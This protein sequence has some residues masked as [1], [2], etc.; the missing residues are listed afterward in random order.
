MEEVIYNLF[1]LREG[2]KIA[3]VIVEK[4]S[5]LFV[6][7]EGRFFS[8]QSREIT[9]TFNRGRG[10]LYIRTKSGNYPCHRL[11]ATA[12]IPNPEKKPAVNHLNGVKT[13]N[14]EKNLEWCS[15][16]DSF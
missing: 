5:I 11:V 1:P 2:E 6:T 13:D 4:E 10:Y 12:F 15:K 8:I 16:S 3:P 9:P 7:N 14:R